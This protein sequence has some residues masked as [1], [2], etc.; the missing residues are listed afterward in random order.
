MCDECGY[1]ICPSRCQ[2]HKVNTYGKC[3]VCG[4]SIYD[5]ELYVD[6]GES[7]AHLDC[8]N[9]NL[10]AKEILALCGIDS[11]VAGSD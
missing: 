11:E 2:N 1:T 6:F 10:T 8:V 9:D 3:S 7:L 4:Q 5:G